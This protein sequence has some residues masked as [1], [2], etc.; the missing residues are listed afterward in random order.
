MASVQ[1]VFYEYE[2]L[3]KFSGLQLNADKTEFLHVNNNLNHNADK[4]FNFKYNST[5]YQV[6]ACKYITICGIRFSNDQ[7]T[8]YEYNII[9]RINAMENQLKRWICRDLTLNGRNMIAKTFGFS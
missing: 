7:Q 2:R 6:L 8:E 9:R 1:A 3:T 5:D 4:H